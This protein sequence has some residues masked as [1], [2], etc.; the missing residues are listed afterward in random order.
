MNYEQ[1]NVNILYYLRGRSSQKPIIENV[2]STKCVN[3]CNYNQFDDLN[4]I[5][6]AWFASTWEPY[7]ELCVPARTLH[8]YYTILSENMDSLY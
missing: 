4:G 3:L 5:P 8:I 7:I 1:I 6:L 2:I